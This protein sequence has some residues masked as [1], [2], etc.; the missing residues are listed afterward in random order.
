MLPTIACNL[1]DFLSAVFEVSLLCSSDS[2]DQKDV[3]ERCR[4]DSEED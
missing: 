2:P 4:G 3:D 1:N